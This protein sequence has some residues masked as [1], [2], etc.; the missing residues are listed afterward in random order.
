MKSLLCLLFLLPATL[1]SQQVLKVNLTF[2]DYFDDQVEHK[3][4]SNE[5]VW[6][7]DGKILNYSID[8]NNLRY[9]DTLTLSDVE[10]EKIT[11]LLKVNEPLQSIKKDLKSNIPGKREMDSEIRGNI[12]FDN[13]TIEIFV[14]SDEFRK[15]KEDISLKWLYDFQQLFFEI[16]DSHNK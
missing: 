13:K 4:T 16:L 7:L 2:G 12:T 8:A 5:R 9:V 3:F 15:T 11:Q 1:F 10:I 6:N 14:K